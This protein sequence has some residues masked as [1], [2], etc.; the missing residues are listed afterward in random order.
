RS[1]GDQVSGM[2]ARPTRPVKQGSTD[3]RILETWHSRTNERPETAQRA[4]TSEQSC[5]LGGA[6]RFFSSRPD[7]GYRSSGR[8]FGSG[9]SLG[10]GVGIRSMR[11]AKLLPS[12]VS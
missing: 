7:S 5:P 8:S 4:E 12:S 10:G 11:V 3:R 9:K 2:L 6:G 1:V